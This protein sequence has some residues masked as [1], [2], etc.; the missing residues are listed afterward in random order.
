MRVGGEGE[1]LLTPRMRMYAPI[2][3]AVRLRITWKAGWER[4]TAGLFFFFFCQAWLTL[5]K[6]RVGFES[7]G[8]REKAALR[9]R[10][11]PRHPCASF[12]FDTDTDTIMCSGRSALDEH[13]TALYSMC[14]IRLVPTHDVETVWRPNR[15]ISLGDEGTRL[16]A[17][18]PF[19]YREMSHSVLF[20]L[21]V[22]LFVFFR[23]GAGKSRQA[24]GMLAAG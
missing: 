24:G 11:G 6:N 22:F 2:H 21:F 5:A 7:S 20:V 4:Q 15:Y 17:C 3:A 9:A 23:H 14:I 10:A 12:S 19:S 13:S 18:T 16:G 8:S 1:G